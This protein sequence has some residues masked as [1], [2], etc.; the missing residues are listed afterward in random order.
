MMWYS[1]GVGIITAKDR[2]TGEKFVYIGAGNGRDEE[3]DACSI[4]RLGSK[5][6][7]NEFINHFE[8][9]KTI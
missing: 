1:Y 7:L 4:L 8:K 3:I 2:M 9:M 6:P 5:T